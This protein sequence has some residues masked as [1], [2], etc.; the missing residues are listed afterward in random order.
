M[1][2]HKEGLDQSVQGRLG[3]LI[4]VIHKLHLYSLCC[5]P[6]EATSQP[7]LNSHLGDSKTPFLSH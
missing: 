1:L 4:R 5:I 2:L 3:S 6:E 7:P